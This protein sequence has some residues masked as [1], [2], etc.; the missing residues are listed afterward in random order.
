MKQ[1]DFGNIF[2]HSIHHKFDKSVCAHRALVWDLVKL[3]HWVTKTCSEFY[4][5]VSESTKRQNT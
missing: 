2:M 4:S 1:T 3:W 5:C